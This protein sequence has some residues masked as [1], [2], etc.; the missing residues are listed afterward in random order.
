MLWQFMKVGDLVALKDDDTLGPGVIMEILGDTGFVQVFW[1]DVS[2][3]G[4]P[5]MTRQWIHNLCL[6]E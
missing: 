5:L 1:S 3:L 4:K 6:I 2:Q